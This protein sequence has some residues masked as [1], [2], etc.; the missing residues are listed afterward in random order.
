MLN[1]FMDNNFIR[2]LIQYI[3]IEDEKN[4]T[5]FNI[6][7]FRMFNDLFRNFDLDL[8]D[9]FIEH[10]NILIDEKTKEKYKGC[11]R[12]DLDPRRMYCLIE[13]IRTLIN[14]KTTGN[15][16]L[17]TS[18]WFLVLKRTIF[19]W[20]IPTLWCAINEYVKEMLDHPYKAV[21]EYIANLHCV[22][23]VS[24]SFDIKL[25]NGQSTHHPDAN[26]FIDTIHERLH[27]AIEIYERKP[28][29]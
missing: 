1:R 29:G 25:P 12:E 16:F 24:L 2:K 18:R 14:N 15:T 19:E 11:Y 10:L 5:N 13:F 28:L 3:V 21:R 17:E 6:H 9:H 20:R 26:R 22:L 27:Q 23:S 8:I 4:E 7:R